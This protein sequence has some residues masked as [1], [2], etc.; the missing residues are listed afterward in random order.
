[1][2][3]P[4][5]RD[6]NFSADKDDTAPGESTSAAETLLNAVSSAVSNATPI[7]PDAE[8]DPED[9]FAEDEVE[10]PSFATRSWWPRSRDGTTRATQRAAPSSTSS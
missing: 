7:S 4:R 8:F 9:D 3:S 6:G 10:F 2:V 5:N 1:M